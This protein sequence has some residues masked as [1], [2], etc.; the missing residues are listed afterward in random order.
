MV[1]PSNEGTG[2]LHPPLFLYAVKD[3]KSGLGV[4]DVEAG[5]GVINGVSGACPLRRGAR[6]PPAARPG[7]RVLLDT[8]TLLVTRRAGRWL[9]KMR[10]GRQLVLPIGA[11]R[12]IARPT[13][14][15]LGAG[16][17]CWGLGQSPFWV[18]IP[19]VA[20]CQ[21]AR[22]SRSL[23]RAG[24]AGGFS[25]LLLRPFLGRSADQ[26]RAKAQPPRRVALDGCRAIR[27]RFCRLRQGRSSVL[28]IR[29]D[30]TGGSS[31]EAPEGQG[32]RPQSRSERD[33]GPGQPL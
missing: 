5:S 25:A 15:R 2:R 29:P 17:P 12:L 11:R 10:D 28:T 14:S 4:A 18:A 13:V 16:C 33:G 31:R 21:L 30:G 24:A 26:S 1:P 6:I 27:S 23:A 9:R 20:F 32:R 7:A 22:V 8:Y 19:L 3:G